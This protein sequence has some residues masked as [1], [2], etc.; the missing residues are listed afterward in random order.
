MQGVEDSGKRNSAILQLA[1]NRRGRD[2]FVGDIHGEY[3]LLMRA[4]EM[5]DFDEQCD[6]LISVGDLVDRGPD[7]AR[8]LMFILEQPKWFHSILGNHELMLAA[9]IGN[10]PHGA[11]DVWSYN[12]GGWVD[13]EILTEVV[14]GILAKLPLAIELILTDGRKAG[15]IHAELPPEYT[16]AQIASRHITLDDAMRQGDKLIGSLLWGRRRIKSALRVRRSVKATTVPLYDRIK[17]LEDLQP[18]SDLDLLIMGHTQLSPRLPL[19]VGNLQWIDTGAGYPR[20]VL[21]LVDPV[22][23][24]C[25]QAGNPRSARI[26]DL[27]PAVDLTRW[28]LTDRQLS[29]SRV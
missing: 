10:A 13:A 9:A 15:V 1:Q 12:G 18:V 4:L 5:A 2:W 16:W 20:G 28:R 8:M 19:R 25:I 17:A 27:P 24:L 29:R 7:S 22:A 11:R 21:S 6:R 14:T 23:G 3:G 26:V